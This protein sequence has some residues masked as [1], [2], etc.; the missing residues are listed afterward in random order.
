M[1]GA[2]RSGSEGCWRI[3]CR[4]RSCNVKVACGLGGYASVAAHFA[5][6]P[7]IHHARSPRHPWTPLIPCDGTLFHAGRDCRSPLQCSCRYGPLHLDKQ[8][9]KFAI[10]P[11]GTKVYCDANGYP[12]PPRKGPHAAEAGPDADAEN[13]HDISAIGDGLKK[14]K[15]IHD[16]VMNFDGCELT[17]ISTSGHGLKVMKKIQH[18]GCTST[19]AVSSLTPRPLGTVSRI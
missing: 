19:F 4:H 2:G 10:L 5:G 13:T 8:G 15:E 7:A 12:I 6:Q 17:D 11:D 1:F 3:S 14:I 18:L 9:R 16:L